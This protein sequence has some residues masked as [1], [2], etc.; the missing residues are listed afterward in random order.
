MDI[1]KIY[2]M[3]APYTAPAPSAYVLGVNVYH[4]IL[5]VSGPDNWLL[6]GLVALVGMVGIESTGGLAAILVS[7]AYVNKSWSIMGMALVA[8]AAYAAFVGWGIYTGKESASMITTVAITLLCYLVIALQE[9]MKSIEGK[10]VHVLQATA[11]KTALIDAQRK[12]QNSLNRGAGR[13]QPSSAVHLS[14]GQTGQAAPAVEYDQV[15]LAAVMAVMRTA[16]A[17]STR[18]LVAAGVGVKSPTS[19]AKYRTRALELIAAEVV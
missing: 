4:S 18:D 10:Q 2:T 16:P 12:L 17:S 7:K 15:V 1:T 11:A 3:V 19:A 8:V 5:K 13:V 14:S 9:G 6:A